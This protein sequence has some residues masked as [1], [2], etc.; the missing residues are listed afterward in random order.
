MWD[1]YLVL[2]PIQGAVVAVVFLIIAVVKNARGMKGSE[3][4]TWN[5]IGIVCFLY[6]FTSA[7]WIA[8]G[9]PMS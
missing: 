6:L 5:T 3:A 9:S 8:F 4:F 7:A 2:L 1:G